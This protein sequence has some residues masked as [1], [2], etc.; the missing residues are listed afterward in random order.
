LQTIY[1]KTLFPLNKE[2]Y[3]VFEFIKINVNGSNDSIEK[4]RY[5]QMNN[6]GL[7]HN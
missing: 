7:K 2:R 6:L 3:P 5:D 1:S 4:L